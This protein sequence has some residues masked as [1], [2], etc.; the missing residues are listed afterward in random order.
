MLP[1]HLGQWHTLLDGSGTTVRLRLHQAGH[2]L[3][4][5]W[6]EL[7]VSE[8]GQGAQQ[9]LFSGDLGATDTPLLPDPALPRCGADVLVMESTYG[10]RLHDDRRTRRQRLQAVLSRAL[11][12]RGTV[13]IPAFSVG[14]TQ[15]L[16]Y[17][18]EDIL[19]T[20]R[21]SAAAPGLPWQDLLIVVDSPLAADFTRGYARLRAHW[22]EEARARLGEGR[23]P[24]DFAQLH[25]VGTHDQHLQVVRHLAHSG[26]PAVV[27]AAS[28]M[29]AGG[30]I[31]N[32]LKALLPDARTDVLLCGYQA[33]GTPG[34]QIQAHEHGQGPGW[35]DLDGERVPV[36]AQVHTLGGYSAHADQAGLLAFVAGLPRPPREIRLVH[37]DDDAKATLARLL[38][39]RCP[40]SQV[41]VPQG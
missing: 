30:R 14:R 36:R 8:P 15:E 11:A 5:A 13:L 10:D 31:V 40:E 26:E 34:R 2:I 4:S 3:G 27:I 21:E 24:L 35:V 33:Q 17:E 16:L 41:L 12:N 28:G 39:T 23:H 25:T 9:V 38:R 1:L 18:L 37:G 7:Q 6:V 20:Q 22:D 29:C 19:H 32:H